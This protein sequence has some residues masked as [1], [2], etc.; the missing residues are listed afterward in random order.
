MKTKDQLVKTALSSERGFK[1]AVID[2]LADIRNSIIIAILSKDPNSTYLS[3]LYDSVY[4]E[5]RRLL[6]EESKEKDHIS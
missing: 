2:L 3:E 5:M 6:N 1:L 4:R